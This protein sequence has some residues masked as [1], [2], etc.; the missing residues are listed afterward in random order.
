[1]SISMGMKQ[2]EGVKS[3]GSSRNNVGRLKNDVQVLQ[4]CVGHRLLKKCV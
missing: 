1:M 3:L 4:K 2:R